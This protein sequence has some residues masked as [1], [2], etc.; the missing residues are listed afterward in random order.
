MH[1]ES[2]LASA[3][4]L[5]GTSFINRFEDSLSAEFEDPA[6]VRASSWAL[7]FFRFSFYL[8]KIE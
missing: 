2:T 5:K 8:V 4:L 7:S 1:A 6:R 3:Q